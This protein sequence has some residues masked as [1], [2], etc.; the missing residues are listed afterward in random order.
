MG[1]AFEGQR[2]AL[3][4]KLQVRGTPTL[5]AADGRMGAGV[6]SA[7]ALAAWLDAGGETNGSAAAAQ[8]RP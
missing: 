1:T 7:S 4:E 8:E 3:A 5:I 2:L 6:M